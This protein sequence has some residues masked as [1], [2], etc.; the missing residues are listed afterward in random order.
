M[1]GTLFDIIKDSIFRE[2][3]MK[4]LLLGFYLDTFLLTKREMTS[5]AS[6]EIGFVH[7]FQ[8]WVASQTTWKTTLFG[9]R[10]NGLFPKYNF[11]R[12]D[13]LRRYHTPEI[14]HH[15]LKITYLKFPII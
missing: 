7:I 13:I 3:E 4:F 2:N 9:S 6:E 15:F 12:F 14:D 10:E 1:F 11:P 8:T 5:R